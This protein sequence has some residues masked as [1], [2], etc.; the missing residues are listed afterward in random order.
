MLTYGTEGRKWKRRVIESR[1]VE[2]TFD[3]QQKVAGLKV[4]TSLDTGNKLGEAA[5]EIVAWNVQIVCSSTYLNN[6]RKPSSAW[7]ACRVT[8]S[9]ICG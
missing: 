7:T 2:I 4:I 5:V 1:P 8:M 6:V 3:A 9:R